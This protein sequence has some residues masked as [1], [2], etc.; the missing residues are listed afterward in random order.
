[1]ANDSSK[2]K[3]IAS[4]I[5]KHC[6][7]KSISI[8]EN[9]LEFYVDLLRL[10]P[11]I[12]SFINSDNIPDAQFLEMVTNNLKCQNKP[13]V[14]TLKLQWYYKTKFQTK[15]QL[16]EENRA[17][18]AKE[19]SEL[20]KYIIETKNIS[21]QVDVN[22][23][24]KRIL[25]YI[26][27]TSGLGSPTNEGVY[28]ETQSALKSVLSE[29]ELKDFTTL[30]KHQKLDQLNFFMK[31]VTGIKI[32]HKDCGK[33]GDAIVDLPGLLYKS[34]DVTREN[35]RELLVRLMQ[36]IN[37]LTTVIDKSYKL[38][39]K[40]DGNRIMRC[41]LPES[42]TEDDMEY[43]KSL[44]IA[45]R[46][47]EIYLRD[48]MAIIEDEDNV[49]KIFNRLKITLS[50]IHEICSIRV[51]VSCAS[52]YPLF[53]QLSDIWTDIQNETIYLSH[54]NCVLEKLDYYVNLLDYPSKTLKKMLNDDEMMTDAQ[55]L[56]RFAD[57]KL[58]LK[59]D[60]AFM[61]TINKNRNIDS[62]QI[63]CIR[64]DPW[65]L[66]QTGGGLFPGIP[67]MGMALT[68]KS[69]QFIFSEPDSAREFF[70]NVSGNISNLC[71]LLAKRIEL[72]EMFNARKFMEPLKL[73]QGTE[74]SKE[75]S[76]HSVAI[77]TEEIKEVMKDYVWNVWELKRSAL[78]LADL[79]R[80]STKS[81]MTQHR[82][83]D[84][85]NQTGEAAS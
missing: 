25:F 58:S 18:L 19:L 52:I 77:Q 26:T 22:K 39:V 43:I 11:E 40:E 4:N 48:I 55:R 80:K 38:T 79:R 9:F 8:D 74:E 5:L 31:L 2:T 63:E 83:L 81:T 84:E 28:Q 15:H 32:F 42:V 71:S 50:R 3:S 49:N 78:K 45:Y 16:N 46:Q 21:E 12:D 72:I 35:L 29:K 20:K 7:R 53:E 10:N 23:M 62:L 68:Q 37:I 54:I 36:K 69:Q 41:S 33:G 44:L 61:T 75:Q 6:Y 82:Q 47:Y 51:A 1:M 76:V 17:E 85:N 65:K 56:Q 14:V 13:Q 66:V 70:K 67:T 24:F 57:V 73:T 59:T 30:P 60:E 34:L 64:C 27:L